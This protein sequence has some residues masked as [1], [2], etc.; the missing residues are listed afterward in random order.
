MNDI[1]KDNFPSDEE[2]VQRIESGDRKAET[3]LYLKFKDWLATILHRQY[4][5][6]SYIPDVLQAT[7]LSTIEKIRNN[8]LRNP[9]ALRP[10]LRQSALNIAAQFH[11]KGY[12]SKNH[13]DLD[14]FPGI[15]DH[16]DLFKDIEQ[17]DLI[18]FTRRCINE[19][20]NERDQRILILFYYKHE[21]KKDICIELKLTTE[22]FDRVLYRARQRLRAL[23]EEKTKGKP[24]GD[25]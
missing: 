13:L 6:R 20:P 5:G 22:H 10:F 3:L 14:L 12:D 21:D 16:R 18:D 19:L 24:R 4:Y 11:N 15:Q 25:E 23:V 9:S 17:K 7:F 1:P 2:L 8:K